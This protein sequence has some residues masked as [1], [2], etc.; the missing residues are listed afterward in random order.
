MIQI[1]FENENFVV[2]NKPGQVLS[3]PSRD[4]QDPRPCLGLELQ[5]KYAQEIFPVH[6]LDFE[7]SGLIIY[8]FNAKAHRVSQSWF[9]KKIIMKTYSAR[10]SL[11]DFSHWPAG[12]KTDFT[13]I[14]IHQEGEFFWATKIHRGKKRSFESEHGDWAETKARI[15]QILPDELIWQLNPLTGKPH[16]LRLE[17][18]RH[19]FPIHGDALYGSKVLLNQPGIALQ[20]VSLDLSQVGERLGL[21]SQINLKVNE[22]KS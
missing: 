20:A 6:R 2:C 9:D 1:I 5:K 16:Q 8:A 10:T 12:L 11:Q 18:S 22:F 7:V 21:P 4:R 14:D 13:K 19:G 15:V 17:L 3:V